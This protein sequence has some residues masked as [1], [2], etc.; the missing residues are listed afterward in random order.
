MKGNKTDFLKE[1]GLLNPKPQRVSHP[2]FHQAN[3]FDPLDLPQVRYEMLRTARVDKMSVTEACNQYGVSREYFYTCLRPTWICCA[4]GLI[5]GT[6]T[7]T[8]VEPRHHQLYHPRKDADLLTLRR[9]AAQEDI[10][11]L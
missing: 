11:T 7:T 1:R 4:F 3:F 9:T 8:G 10:A 5:H 2:Q 6:T